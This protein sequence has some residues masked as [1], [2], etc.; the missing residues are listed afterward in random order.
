MQ[1]ALDKVISLLIDL[2][3]TPSPYFGVEK[4]AGWG[5][6]TGSEGWLSVCAD[7]HT[8]LYSNLMEQ[9]AAGCHSSLVQFY[10]DGAAMA[11]VLDP[12]H[13]IEVVAD[14]YFVI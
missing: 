14:L 12:V 10:L 3:S 11:D 6:D 1:T 4:A 9:V 7:N 8:H 5:T 13:P 2:Q